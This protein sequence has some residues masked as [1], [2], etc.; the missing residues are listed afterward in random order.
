MDRVI[1]RL[2]T[3]CRSS[4]RGPWEPVR[5]CIIDAKIGRTIIGQCQ[6]WTLRRSKVPKKTLMAQI[7]KMQADCF[8]TSEAQLFPDQYLCLVYKASLDFG[9]K[10]MSMYCPAF[11]DS[12]V[13][14]K[15]TRRVHKMRNT[16]AIRWAFK[17]LAQ[18][19][20]YSGSLSADRLMLQAGR[21]CTSEQIFGAEGERLN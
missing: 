6:H 18:I 11:Q 16:C 14:S 15:L 21:S 5:Q 10:R 2:S 4:G 13:V 7:L 3:T 9:L 17:Q 1:E 8:S 20:R 12:V 19:L